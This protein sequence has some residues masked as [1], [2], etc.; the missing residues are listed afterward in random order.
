MLVSLFF[1]RMAENTQQ[2][3]RTEIQ[4]TKKEAS[5]RD[6]FRSCSRVSSHGKDKLGSERENWDR[7]KDRFN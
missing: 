6:A 3:K 4:H 1:R 7:G 2:R 5:P